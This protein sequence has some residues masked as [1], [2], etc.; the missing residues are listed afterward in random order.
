MLGVW[1]VWL[2]GGFGLAILEVL[3]PGYIFAGFALGAA[4]TGI[5]M[6]LGLPGS[7]WMAAGAVNALTV[8]AGLSVVSWLALRQGMG[9]RKGQVKRVE[10][11]VNE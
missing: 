3:V 6:G 10:H 11:D 7:G 9:L 4:G 2:A 5:W 8:F 1:W